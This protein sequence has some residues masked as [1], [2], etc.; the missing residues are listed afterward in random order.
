MPATP[1]GSGLT[2][3]AVR[4][5]RAL[6]HGRRDGAGRAD[7]V[8]EHLAEAIRRGLVAPGE[9]LPA[10]A[11]LAEQLGVATLTLREALSDLRE[12]G[13]L[14][15]RRGRNGG[16]FVA[17]PSSDALSR[18]GLAGLTVRQLR[19][20]GDQRQAVL[21][22]AAELAAQ[23][24]SEIEI[25]ALRRRVD[26]LSAA[27]KPGERRRADSEFGIELAAAAQSP[28]IAQH[29]ANLRAELGDLVWTLLSDTEHEESVRVRCALVDAV[30]DGKP[31]AARRLARQHIAY[32][33]DLLLQW[34][35]DLYRADG[36]PQNAWSDLADDFESVFADLEGAAQEF[37][38]SFAANAGDGGSYLTSD[39]AALRPRIHAT[40]ERFRS[41]AVG[42]GIV[43]A[44]QV[45]KDAPYWLE[46]WWRQEGGAPESLRVN[47]DPDGPD[48]FDYVTNE[49]Y[50]VPITA[51]RRHVAG[52]YLDYACTN[53]YTFTFS[54]PAYHQGRP[55]GVAAMDVPC[56]LIER[57]IMPALCAA[58]SP[59]ALVNASGRVIAANRTAAA[60][61]RARPAPRRDHREHRE[62]DHETEPGLARLCALTGWITQ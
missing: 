56:D 23:R 16:S 42:T 59:H 53:Q 50:D 35:I 20:L 33:T 54:V 12:R 62:H 48:F 31:E 39:I 47:L 60:G 38:A 8:A 26:R 44:P 17:R 51:G 1:P 10:E 58:A 30:A 3:A 15:T 43:V 7:Q 49:W 32:E 9:R 21:G 11:A 37:E 55:L 25:A 34:R 57:R 22:T 4:A 29:E 5:I 27:A 52:P 18:S 45:L 6:G 2:T 46:W 40:L 28:R 19:E 13:L 61:T 24:A 41:I 14:E 36:T